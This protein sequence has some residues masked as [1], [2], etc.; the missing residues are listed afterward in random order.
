MNVPFGRRV[1]MAALG[2]IVMFS[3]AVSKLK[4]QS[5]QSSKLNVS[6]LFKDQVSLKHG[7]RDVRAQVEHRASHL[8][9]ERVFENVTSNWILVGCRI[10]LHES[11]QILV[12]EG[13]RQSNSFLSFILGW[14]TPNLITGLSG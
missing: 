5:S 8:S 14:G 10:V 9:F 6:G 1:V 13:H 3:N 11:L 7:K 4:A 12:N 2:R